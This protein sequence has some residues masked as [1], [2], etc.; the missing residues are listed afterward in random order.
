MMENKILLLRVPIEL[1]RKV[2]SQKMLPFPFAEGIS[3]VDNIGLCCFD[4]LK[5]LVKVNGG[6]IGMSDVIQEKAESYNR[7]EFYRLVSTSKEAKL[8]NIKKISNDL[9]VAPCWF[10]NYPKFDGDIVITTTDDVVVNNWLNF[11]ET[12]RLSK[13]KPNY[14]GLLDK[15]LAEI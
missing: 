5:L 9:N 2:K 15:A 13:P 14:T 8:S 4:S 12:V 6:I 7:L 10:D 3:D 11:K 1:I